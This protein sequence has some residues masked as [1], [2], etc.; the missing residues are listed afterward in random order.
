M[1]SVLPR[2][3]DPSKSHI[4]VQVFLE[5]V[6]IAILM[7]RLGAAMTNKWAVIAVA[8]LFAGGHIP[9]IVSEGASSA[10]LIGLLRDFAIG[11]V[12]IGSAVRGADILWLWPVHYALDMTQFL[13][14]TA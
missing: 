8:A 2:V 14:K 4:A 12:V 13:G 11:V 3:F 9:S 5:D 1:Q 10:E 7:V 6:T